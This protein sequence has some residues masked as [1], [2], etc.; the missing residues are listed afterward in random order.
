MHFGFNSIGRS[1]LVS[2]EMIDVSEDTHIVFCP[3]SFLPKLY[4]MRIA[5]AFSV[6]TV[7][8]IKFFQAFIEEPL[9]ELTYAI[10]LYLSFCVFILSHFFMVFN[11]QI[12]KS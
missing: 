2:L 4:M 6:L 3:L 9:R 11:M 7:E 1:P 5:A 10:G 8:P 12:S